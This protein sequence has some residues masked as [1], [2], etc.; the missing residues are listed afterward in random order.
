MKNMF[1]FGAPIALGLVLSAVP[2]AAEAT[3][4]ELDPSH[5]RIGFAVKH[6]MVSTTKGHFKKWGGVV[7]I[8]DKDP[9]KSKIEI[10][11]DVASVDTDDEKRD[12]HLRNPDF[13]DVAKHPKMTFK[14]TKIAKAPKGYKVTGDLTIKGVTKPVTLMIE[15][16]AK[17]AKDPWGNE[18]TGISGTGV[19]NREDYGLT[20]NAVLETGGVAVGKDVK[21]EL[22]VEMIKKKAQ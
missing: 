1:R 4:W 20:Y 22:E 11:I 2:T 17:P 13:F 6:L 14:A 18:R 7:D 8:D 3:Q 12:E 10:E 5:S 16:P 9:T 21:L 15:G 19:I